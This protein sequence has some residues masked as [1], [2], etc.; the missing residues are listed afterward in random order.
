MKKRIFA[1]L[2]LIGICFS[3]YAQSVIDNPVIDKTNAR[4]VK[5]TKIEL[6]ENETVLH[7]TVVNPPNL[8]VSFSSQTILKDSKS[9]RKYKLLKCDGYPLDT[10]HYMP[11]GRQDFK[12]YFEPLMPN[13]TKV[14]FEE[15]NEQGAFRIFGI[16]IKDDIVID[17]LEPVVRVLVAPGERIIIP[18]KALRKLK[19][20]QELIIEGLMR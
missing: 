9:S 17:L 13:V 2:L 16:V 14:D 19:K 20:N 6:L 3:S 15:G 12:M 4:N 10:K 11:S 18:A 8:W 1:M 7:I 5:I